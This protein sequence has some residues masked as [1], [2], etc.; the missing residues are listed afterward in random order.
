[1]KR[2]IDTAAAS[3]RRHR[4]GALAAVFAAGLAALSAAA[5]AAAAQHLRAFA[6]DAQLGDFIDRIA[7]RHAR[8]VPASDSTTLDSI[9]VTGS[10]IRDPGEA[11]ITNVQTAGVD[12][13]GIVKRHGDFLIVLRRG[14]LFVL[15]IGGE[16]LELASWA[17]AA[18]VGRADA[19]DAW[20]DEILVS[21]GTVALVGYNHYEG[22]TELALFDLSAQGRLQRRESHHL[23]SGDYY[24]GSNYASRLVGRTLVLYA[25]V[26]LSDDYHHYHGDIGPQLPA[27]RQWREGA[28]PSDYQRI[29]P[30]TQIYRLPGRPDYDSAVLHHLSFCDLGQ[31]PLRCRGVGVLGHWGRSLYVSGQ[32]AYLWTAVDRPRPR[33]DFAA[34]FRFPLDGGAPQALRASGMPVAPTG[35]L[36]RGGWLNVLVGDRGDGDA[37]W[38]THRD[39]G[40][41]ALLRAPLAA[42][43][44]GRRAVPHRQY[45]PLPSPGHYFN[46]PVR[47]VGDWLLWGGLQGDP[48]L[49]DS[50]DAYALRYAG[51]AVHRLRLGH[52]VDRVDAIG[53]HGIA[54]GPSEDDDALHFSSLRLDQTAR[55]AGHYAQPGVEESERRTHAFFYRSLGPEQGLL[56][57]P[58]LEP[59]AEATQ[60]ETVEEDDRSRSARL[61]F[62]GNDALR[63]RPLGTLASSPGPRRD[64]GCK[65]SCI[66][67][68]GDARPIFIGERV[69]ALLGYELVEGRVREG[70]VE[71]VRRLDFTPQPQ[72]AP[73]QP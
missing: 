48:D 70:R 36:E 61:L 57:L 53:A 35:F 1:M 64:D 39:Q 14:R 25:P 63:L 18:P 37:F 10:V 44:N 65:V 49:P 12:E 67:W 55:V 31:R 56:G 52:R 3:P 41:L 19:N 66:D 7:A 13:G 38:A 72:A 68:Y 5:P 21:D 26:N 43:G 71:E 34:V 46:V 2:L 33:S 11:G 20:Y 17:D 23:R 4:A 50:A 28:G 15:R 9:V 54:V 6:D 24:S 42:F 45:R 40:N 16:R 73:A 51:G 29:T 32:A 47:F 69:F 30:A 60:D 58:V 27:Q 62:L 59:L 22:A 8:S